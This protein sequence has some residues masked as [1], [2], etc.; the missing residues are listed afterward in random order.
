MNINSPYWKPPA[1]FEKRT[2]Q[3]QKSNDLGF[4]NDIPY[5]LPSTV[6]ANYFGEGRQ[7]LDLPKELVYDSRGEYFVP[8]NIVPSTGG[9]PLVNIYSDIYK[10]KRSDYTRRV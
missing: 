5:P 7:Y 6:G 2:Y 3:T 9:K 1:E 10:H 4:R 8:G